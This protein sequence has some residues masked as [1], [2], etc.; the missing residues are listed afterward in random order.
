MSKCKEQ[1]EAA[2]ALLKCGQVS[3][4]ELKKIN[5]KYPSDPIYY[6]RTV[7]K[8]EVKS[9]KENRKTVYFLPDTTAQEVSQEPIV[10]Q[11]IPV[12]AEVQ[13][14]SLPKRYVIPDWEGSVF[15]K[16]A[17]NFCAKNQWRVSHVLGDYEDCLAKCALDYVICCQR[18]GATVNSAQHFMFMYTG[19]VIPEFHTLAVRDGAIRKLHENLPTT[20]EA[21]FSDAELSVSLSGAS[22]E[23]K[24]VLKI[25]FN[26]P[27]EMMET[28]R[29][30]A[31]SCHPKQFW[32]AAMRMAGVK[33][34]RASI[35]IK[36]LQRLL[37]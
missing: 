35:L 29:Q 7:L 5:E 13:P 14:D 24:S 33:V 9:K 12:P 15:Q 16:W 23:L 6:I 22:D 34:N 11:V 10:E 28:L 25:I 2:L 18:Y 4:D 36:E 20:E 8:I 1:S 17:K 21:V 32:K 37:T 27:Q 31:S 30:E 26:A 19:W 3:I